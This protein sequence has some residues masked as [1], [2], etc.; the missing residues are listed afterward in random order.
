MTPKISIRSFSNDQYILDKVFY[1]NFYRLKG[2]R[3]PEKQPTV[4]DIGAHCGYFTFTALA[5]G[6]KR[7]YAFEPFIENLKVLCENSHN[8]GMG[9]VLI[10]QLGVNISDSN[11]NFAYPERQ[12]NGNF[13][14]FSE[15]DV[16]A[17]NAKKLCPCPCLTLDKILTHYVF[18]DVDILKINIGYNESEILLG[19]KIIETKVKNI[20]GEVTITDDKVDKFKADMLAKGFINSLIEKSPDDNRSFFIF[21]KVNLDEYFKT[22]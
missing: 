1:A 12:K 7:V 17:V 4:V 18:D 13:F 11:L 10:H 19:S 15:I 14:N 2:I 9:E 21:S 20:C 22:N 3:E 8:N 5:L 6:A 16:N